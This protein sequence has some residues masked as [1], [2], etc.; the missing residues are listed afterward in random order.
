M[1]FGY[2]DLRK[3]IIMNFGVLVCIRGFRDLGGRFWKSLEK[4]NVCLIFIGGIYN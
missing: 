1:K 3:F 4:D 2:I